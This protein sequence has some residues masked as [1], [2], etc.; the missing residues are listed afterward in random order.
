MNRQVPPSYHL[1]YGERREHCPVAD[2]KLLKD[3]M[4][5]HLD[6]PSVIFSR[7]PISLFD[8][9]GRKTPL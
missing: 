5:V 9:D 7:R 6:V 2:F 4:E 8:N 3:V 1:R